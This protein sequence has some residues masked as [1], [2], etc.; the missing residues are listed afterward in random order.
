VGRPIK[1]D[2]FEEKCQENFSA[3]KFGYIK[4]IPII[5][6]YWNYEDIVETMSAKVW[7][8]ALAERRPEA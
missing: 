4:M 1:P 7:N 2:I 6:P 8:N 3:G 5:S